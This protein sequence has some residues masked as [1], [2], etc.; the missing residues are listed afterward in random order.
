MTITEANDVNTLVHRLMGHRVPWPGGPEITDANV[1]A[2]ARRLTAKA[3][4][5]LS[6]GL[7]PEDVEIY[8]PAA[9]DG[10]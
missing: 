9:P 5:A 3:H 6:A 4:K 1:T 10:A 2:A 7:R 8:T